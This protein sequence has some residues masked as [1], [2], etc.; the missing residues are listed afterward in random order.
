MPEAPKGGGPFELSAPGK[1]EGLFEQAQLT[2]LSSGEIDCPF[3]YPDFE[4]FWQGN[5]G[6]GPTQGMLRVVTEDHLRAAAYAA[7]APFRQDDGQNRD[8]AEYLSFCGG[9]AVDALCALECIPKP[10]RRQPP[11]HLPFDHTR[12]VPWT[13]GHKNERWA[14]R[15]IG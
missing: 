10:R 4:T 1:L 8:C 12:P 3:I 14:L 7:L 9:Y 5:V 2:V 6:A 11:P 13:L 15:S